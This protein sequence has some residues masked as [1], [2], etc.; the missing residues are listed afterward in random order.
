[1]TNLNQTIHFVNALVAQETA[2]RKLHNKGEGK[3]HGDFKTDRTM[4]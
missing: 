3:Q 1:M 4:E 2:N